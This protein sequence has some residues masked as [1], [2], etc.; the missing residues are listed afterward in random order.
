MTDPNPSVPDGVPAA[1]A[2]TAGP[3]RRTNSL[4]MI[5]LVAGLCGLSLVPLIGSIIAVV[6]GHRAL[7]QIQQTDQS[8]AGLARTGLGLGY[9]AIALAVLVAAVPLVLVV[10]RSS[11]R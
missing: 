6:T 2:P 4:A 10:V 8:G 11:A 1:P 7:R 3:G 5:S 9:F